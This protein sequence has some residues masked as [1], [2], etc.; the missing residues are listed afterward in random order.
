SVWRPSGPASFYT[1]ERD[2]TRRNTAVSQLKIEVVRLVAVRMKHNP[3]SIRGPHHSLI[4]RV[5]G[6]KDTPGF[7]RYRFRVERNDSEVLRNIRIECIID[8]TPPGTEGERE[9]LSIRR[10]R[11]RLRLE[12]G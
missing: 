4:F 3:L 12:C 1:A 5:V 2:L 8:D 7:L 11:R 9:V 6:L 10:P